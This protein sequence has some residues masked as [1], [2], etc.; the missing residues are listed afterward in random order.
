V[1]APRTEIVIQL[2]QGQVD[3]LGSV[4]DLTIAGAKLWDAGIRHA[5]TDA[6][7]WGVYLPLF[8]GVT[9]SRL[10]PA[11]Q[12]VVRDAWAEVRD[13]ARAYTQEELERGIEAIRAAGV[14]R[15]SP[16]EQDR[17]QMQNRLIAA[18]DELVRRGRMDP[19]FVQR[20]RERLEALQ[21]A[22]P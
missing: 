20:V 14:V 19:E 21:Q 9:W 6:S 17:L 5:F 13:W 16:T 15:R 11:H 1:P 2:S 7:G 12:R 4:T 8:S 10:S 22:E 3:G 18:E